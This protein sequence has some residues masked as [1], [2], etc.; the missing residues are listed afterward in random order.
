MAY[1]ILLAPPAERQLKALAEPVQKRIVKRLKSLREN[2]R[3]H[4]IKKLAG[5]EDLYRI[6]EGDYRIIYTI[7]DKQL[8][9]LV[10]KIGDRKAIYR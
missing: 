3:P 2:P 5:E 7:Q 6:R 1:S 8:I 10:V 4:G 9:V